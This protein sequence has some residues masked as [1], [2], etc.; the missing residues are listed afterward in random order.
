MDYIVLIYLFLMEEIKVTARNI[1]TR[2]RE[3]A[4]KIQS[5]EQ[6]GKRESLLKR[7]QQKS[8]WTYS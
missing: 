8:T 3:T 5:E 1:E 2:E 6:K 4:T 7:G